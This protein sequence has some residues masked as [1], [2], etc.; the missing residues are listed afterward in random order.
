M[1]YFFF[2]VRLDEFLHRRVPQHCVRQWLLRFHRTFRESLAVDL[3]EEEDEL[4][5]VL[6]RLCS[7]VKLHLAES[8]ERWQA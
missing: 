3:R 1:G 2:I 4:L 8:R 6:L 7:S 5:F